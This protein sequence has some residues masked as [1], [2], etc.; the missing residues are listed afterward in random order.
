MST[1]RASRACSGERYSAVPS[2]SPAVVMSNCP[3]WGAPSSNIARPTPMSS[4]FTVLCNV[5]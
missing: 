1:V 2:W 5:V 4:S 3:P